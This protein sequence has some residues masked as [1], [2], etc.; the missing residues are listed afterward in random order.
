VKV[1]KPGML[2][3]WCHKPVIRH[4]QAVEEFLPDMRVGAEPGRLRK[5]L[6]HKK[7]C[8]SKELRS[9]IDLE[10][11][12]MRQQ[13]EDKI[14]HV[15][16]TTE[17]AIEELTKELGQPSARITP[18]GVA[19]HVMVT[20]PE[21]A[22]ELART[23]VVGETPERD[24]P[25]CEGEIMTDAQGEVTPRRPQGERSAKTLPPNRPGDVMA[26]VTAAIESHGG[27]WWTRKQIARDVAELGITSTQE[28]IDQ[29]CYMYGTRVP[30][31]RRRLGLLAEF[32]NVAR[33]SEVV[34]P[35]SLEEVA[36]EVDRSAAQYQRQRE[37]AQE[38]R[39]PSGWEKEKV[40]QA[41]LAIKEHYP[42]LP[43]DTAVDFVAGVIEPS[44]IE[45]SELVPS[46]EM[47]ATT[48]TRNGK[49][50]ELFILK[51]ERMLNELE[52]TMM[53]LVQEAI[54]T[55][56]DQIT[57]LVQEELDG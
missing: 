2:C 29:T 4:Q 31:E 19:R 57:K 34:R 52:R 8:W 49:D 16:E 18:E 30:L 23:V 1:P 35:P 14:G 40:H 33:A 43:R 6:Y 53:Q 36:R 28:S 48:P 27:E 12:G 47:M 24:C 17:E 26:A 55:A 54:K 45:T 51:S 7:R 50:R 9:R 56:R 5:Q 11:L 3:G 37:H 25:V 46:E 32:R 42:E 20:R 38:K 22:S 39:R 44:A 13:T 15:L 21:L 41:A 10:R